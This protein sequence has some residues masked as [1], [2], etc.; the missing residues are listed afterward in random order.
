MEMDQILRQ[1]EETGKIEK[2]QES[3]PNNPIKRV[4]VRLVE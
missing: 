1:L 4:I 2:M 3:I